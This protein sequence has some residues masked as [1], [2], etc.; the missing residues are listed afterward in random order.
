MYTSFR[1]EYTEVRMR[2]YSQHQAIV[3]VKIQVRIKK[4]ITYIMCICCLVVIDRYDNSVT[5][6]T[7]VDI[8]LFN[9]FSSTRW[10]HSPDR[11]V[12]STATTQQHEKGRVYFQLVE[13]AG[14]YVHTLYNVIRSFSYMS[15]LS[16]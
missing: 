4:F 15:V 5:I 12:Y 2:N 16:F 3:T 6:V 13:S 11:G 7:I 9:W 1:V 10:L 14:L 8:D